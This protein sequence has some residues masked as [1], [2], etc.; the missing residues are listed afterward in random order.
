MKSRKRNLSLERV[1][2]W[3]SFNKEVFSSYD[4]FYAGKMLLVVFYNKKKTLNEFYSFV[5]DTALEHFESSDIIA[6]KEF[7]KDFDKKYKSLIWRLENV[8][9][10]E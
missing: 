5:F 9:I 1:L 4:A 7:L 2:W 10:D 6:L 8:S 3:F